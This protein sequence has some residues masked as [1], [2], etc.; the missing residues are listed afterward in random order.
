[1]TDVTPTQAL[2]EETH[3]IQIPRRA[4][5]AKGLTHREARAFAQR[6]Q[7]RTDDIEAY[8]D[9]V[10]VPREQMYVDAGLGKPKFFRNEDGNEQGRFPDA[11]TSPHS[12]KDHPRYANQAE[13]FDGN[14]D[15]MASDSPV[16]AQTM[17][18]GAQRRQIRMARKLSD[19]NLLPAD[20]L[21]KHPVN[22][23]LAREVR[24]ELSA[25]ASAGG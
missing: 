5:S 2:K 15:A 13:D 20:S 17:I 3:G 9:G 19:V 21:I 23:A 11:P 12:L 14:L 1:M 24:R 6:W 4:D 7:D 8:L 16:V 25:G 10:D 18:D 22:S